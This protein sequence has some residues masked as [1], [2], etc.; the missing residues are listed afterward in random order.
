[1]YGI[2]KAPFVA[3]IIPYYPSSTRV[4]IFAQVSNGRDLSG[5]GANWIVLLERLQDGRTFCGR[6]RE[7]QNHKTQKAQRHAATLQKA[8]DAQ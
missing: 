4:L 5:I 3:G 1:M 7:A 2:P 8:S 6:L